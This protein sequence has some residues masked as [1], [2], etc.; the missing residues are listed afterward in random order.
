[1]LDYLQ[2]MLGL[3]FKIKNI[4]LSTADY[5]HIPSLSEYKVLEIEQQPCLL[6]PVPPN[7]FSVSAFKRQQL[8]LAEIINYPM[9]LALNSLTP[10]QRK[11][12]IENKLSFIVPAYQIY[13]PFM[14]LNLQ[15]Y[16]K[17]IPWK[18][19]KLTSMAQI[20]CLYLYYQKEDRGHYKTAIAKTIGTSN[21]TVTRG[22]HDLEI[23]KLVQ[24][25][26]QGRLSL[27][28]RRYPRK[29]Y[30]AKSFPFMVNPIRRTVYVKAGDFYKNLP[31]AGLEAAARMLPEEKIDFIS[32]RALWRR[33]FSRNLNKDIIN[34]QTYQQEYL[35]LELWDYNPQTFWDSEYNTVDKISLVLSLKY[36]N[37]PKKKVLAAKLKELI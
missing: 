31:V 1:M 16:D 13:L 27:V 29:D 3:E 32:T 37:D 34:P 23:L 24:S 22:V 14:A 18:K 36:A 6:I 7:T 8:Q 12:L 19:N 15:E 35:E 10:Y 26:K 5:P 21:M 28:S 17:K 2:D 4:D 9:V 33:K 25:K 11:T 30:L 20:V